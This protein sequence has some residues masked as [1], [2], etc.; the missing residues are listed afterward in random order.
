MGPEKGKPR[1]GYTEA[2]VNRALKLFLGG[3]GNNVNAMLFERR[4]KAFGSVR[5]PEKENPR[6]GMED[7]GRYSQKNKNGSPSAPS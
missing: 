4:L 1:R 5:G 3:R 2:L 7:R 6:P